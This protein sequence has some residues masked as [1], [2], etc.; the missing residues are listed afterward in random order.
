[1]TNC[2]RASV[3]HGTPGAETRRAPFG[4]L[5]VSRGCQAGLVLA[6]DKLWIG[7]HATL[8]VIHTLVLVFF[9][10][11]DAHDRL[12][13]APHDQAGHEDPDK[14]G[15]GADD[16]AAEAGV[17]VGNR[18]QQQAEQTADAVNRDGTDGV[19]NAQLVQG[20]N[21]YHNQQATEGTEDGCQ[22][23]SG[24]VRAGSDG[25]QASQ[26]T[27]QEHG[28]VSFAKHQSGKDQ[29]RETATSRCGV[30]VHEHDGDVVR[31][32]CGGSCQNR[33]TVEAEPAHPQDEGAQSGEG[34]VGA[35]NGTDLA[36]RAVFAFTG[37]Q[38]EHTSQGRS[39]TSH[40]YDARAGKVTVAKI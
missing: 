3:S 29:S 22:K 31:G 18:H 34:Q 35:G 9:G 24:S 20:H 2:S 21:A 33:A 39:C 23:R 26:C 27:V 38:Q 25:Y 15:D 4:A 5:L 7:F 19:V 16:L 10:Y 28:Q 6:A 11:P 37:T 17:A 14:D 32:F 1:M 30:G 40:V 36:V 12:E 13:N 8:G